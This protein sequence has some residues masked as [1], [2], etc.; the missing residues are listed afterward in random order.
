MGLISTV[1][2][3]TATA[4]NSGA[5]E[6]PQITNRGQNGN[7]SFDVASVR[8]DNADRTA[9]THIYTYANQ[10]HLVVVNASLLQLL[11]Y[12]YTLPDSRITGAPDWARSMKFDIEAKADP[13]LVG[14]LA[15]LPSSTAKL[16]LLEMTKTLLKDRFRLAVH[17]EKRQ[18][19]VYDLVVA[20]GGPKFASVENAGNTIDSGTHNGSATITIRSSSHAMAD[21]AEILAGYVGRVVVDQTGLQGSFTIALHFSAM[22]SSS[23]PGRN[24]NAPADDPGPSVFT[25]LN[26]QLGLELK[27]AKAAVDVLAVDHAERPTA[28]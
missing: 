19:P 20:K 7:P 13:A 14:H 27:P 28:N 15:G 24:L 8:V 22:D 12:A 4:Q 9:R 26:E 5:A 1:G 10:G 18:M 23:V 11:Q 2:S 25:A 3:V 21:L 6:P 17:I 16:E